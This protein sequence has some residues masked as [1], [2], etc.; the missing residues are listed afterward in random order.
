MLLTPKQLADRLG[1]CPQTVRR[2]T[3]EGEIPTIKVGGSYR[4]DYESVIKKMA[5]Q[6]RTTNMAKAYGGNPCT[7]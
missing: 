1:V 6:K 7:T 4:Y 3:R 2:L 5:K